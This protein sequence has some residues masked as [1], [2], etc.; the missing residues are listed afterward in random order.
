ME[1]DWDRRLEEFR[2]YL[3]LMARLQLDGRVAAKLSSSDIVQ[4]TLAEAFEKRGQFRGTSDEELAAWLR[5]ALSHNLADAVK[6]LRRAKRDVGLEQ[7]LDA[8]LEKSSARLDAWLAAEQRSPSSCVSR[9]EQ[10]LRLADALAKLPE[11]QAEVVIQHHLKGR[12][13][14]EI[15]AALGKSEP[16]VAG[17]IHRGLVGLRELLKGGD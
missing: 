10:A 7:S 17:L 8:A 1:K 13:L 2:A 11:A 3:G 14:A 16:G 15:A 5:K 4:Q 9:D 6:G 12:T